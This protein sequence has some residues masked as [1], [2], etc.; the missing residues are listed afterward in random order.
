MVIAMAMDVLI[1]IANTLISHVNTE[2]HREATGIRSKLVKKINK[3]T[4]VQ[5]T[6]KER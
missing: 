1:A 5:V 4:V 6:I 3:T 2:R